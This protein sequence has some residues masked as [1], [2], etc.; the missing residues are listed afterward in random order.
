MKLLIDGIFFQMTNT[1]IARVWRTLLNI[2]AQYSEFKLIMLDRGNTP[3]I[4]GINYIPFPRYLFQHSAADS[5]L[6]QKICDEYAVDAFISTYY[7]SPLTTPMLMMV[8]DMIPELF[9]FDMSL[10]GWMDKESTICYSQRYL[11]ISKNTRKDLLSLYPEI[12]IEK[13]AVAHCGIDKEIFYTRPQSEIES[14]SAKY[15]MNCPYFLFVGS[16]TQHNGYK[17]SLLFFK[18]LSGL[19]N[20]QFNVLCVGGEREIEIEIL[21]LLPSKVKCKRVEMSDNELAAAYGGAIALVYPSLYEGFGMPVIEAM[22]C[23]C[24]VITTHNGSLAEAAGDAAHLISGFSV[25]EM[26][27]AIIKI[28]V[29]D[30]RKTLIKRGLQHVPNFKWENML[31]TLIMEFRTLLDES[32]SGQY[33]DFFVEWSRLRKIQASVDLA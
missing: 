18:A 6:I 22:A 14:F 33:D 12:P 2:L 7:T 3:I 17:N 25:D 30:Y 24:P 23:G 19:T 32:R 29:D 5:I 13:T 20:P 10:R 21:R 16:R 11:C 1:G 9:D 8:Y 26:R 15:G 28:Q 27:D 31:D 4:Q